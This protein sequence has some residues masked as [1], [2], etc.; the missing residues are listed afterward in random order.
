MQK[1]IMQKQIM[2]S[3]QVLEQTIKFK[4][5]CSKA[6]LRGDED[7]NVCP[8]QTF[9]NSTIDFHN[10]RITWQELFSKIYNKAVETY[11]E[12][13]SLESLVELLM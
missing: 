13:Y 8:L 9:C 10:F 2:N 7:C 6:G 1:Q 4:G 11:A 3:K 12:K 5:D